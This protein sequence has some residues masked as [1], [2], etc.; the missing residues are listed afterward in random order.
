MCTFCVYLL[1]T[2]WKSLLYYLLLFSASLFLSM[3]KWR[4]LQWL[5]RIHTDMLNEM[6]YPFRLLF[7]FYIVYLITI[8][9]Y[10]ILTSLFTIWCGYE[11]EMWS[12]STQRDFLWWKILPRVAINNYVPVSQS[13]QNLRHL[14]QCSWDFLS[15]L[16]KFFIL[17]GFFLLRFITEKNFF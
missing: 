3:S 12:C 9:D 16:S 10:D 17:R 14:S 4:T 1:F 2:N 13:K 7:L 15:I 11:G 5:K 8:E 6:Q